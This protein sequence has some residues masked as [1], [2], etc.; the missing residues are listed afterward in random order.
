MSVM[1]CHD[2]DK[3]VDTDFNVEHFTA[4][5]G[6]IDTLYEELWSALRHHDWF[7]MMSEDPRVYRDGEKEFEELKRLS[8]MLDEID[9]D[10]QDLWS[11]YCPPNC[12]S[13][14]RW[15]NSCAKTTEEK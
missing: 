2:C 9:S 1:Y 4:D 5:G 8:S 15:L 13:M 3:H 11:E 14:Q 12:P 7:Y 6:C 10:V